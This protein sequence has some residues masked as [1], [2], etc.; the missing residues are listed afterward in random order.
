MSED[1]RVAGLT[2]SQLLCRAVRC[3]IGWRIGTPRWSV[4]SDLFCLDSTSSEE[5][6]REFEVDPGEIRQSKRKSKLLCASK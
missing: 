1:I 3:K 4:I 6:C 5:L 2:D